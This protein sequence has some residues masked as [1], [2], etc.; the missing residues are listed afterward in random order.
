MHVKHPAG[1]GM[2]CM[3]SMDGVDCMDGVD[4]VDGGGGSW[5]ARCNAN[6]TG[7]FN[8]EG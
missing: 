2:D 4:G 7:V 6:K 3:D 1:W 8:R 5:D